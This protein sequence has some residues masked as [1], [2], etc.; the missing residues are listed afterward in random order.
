LGVKAG[1]GA[2]A[3]GEGAIVRGGEGGVALAVLGSGWVRVRVGVGVGRGGGV[4]MG[5]GGVGGGGEAIGRGSLRRT[6]EGVGVVVKVDDIERVAGSVC[7]E[8][9]RGLRRSRWSL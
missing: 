4:A 6:L 3:R 9:R 5:W 7:L 2:G 8:R 1:V